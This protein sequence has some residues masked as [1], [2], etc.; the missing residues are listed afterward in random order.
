MSEEDKSIREI[1]EGI[2]ASDY[3]ISA[4]NGRLAV[5]LSGEKNKDGLE[6]LNGL[7]DVLIFKQ[8]IAQGWDCPRAAILVSYRNVRSEDFGIQTVGRI[9][10]MP[11]RKHYTH[12]DLNHGYVYTN[13]QTNQIKLVPSDSDYFDK[14]LAVRQ[15]DKSWEFAVMPTAQM[16]NDR[17]TSATLTSTFQ[18]I[19][20]NVMENKYGIKQLPDIDLFTPRADDD[21]DVKKIKQENTQKMIEKGWEFEID[22]HQ[23]KIPTDIKVDPY[24]VDAIQITS[25]NR[26]E[27]A[28]TNEEFR[29]FFDRFCYDSITRLIKEKSWRKMRETLINFAEYY[30]QSFEYDAR[31]IYLYPNNKAIILDDIRVALEKFDAWQH[32]WAGVMGFRSSLRSIRFQSPQN[33]DWSIILTHQDPRGSASPAPAPRVLTR[34]ILSTVQ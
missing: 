10:R 27:F 23:I 29:Q 24:Q 6:E 20:F 12:D 25:E 28:I 11:H 2:L 32:R 13:I 17:K 5:W 8:A 9:L 14:L 34:R 19:F 26:K 1:L 15:D 30:L 21:V 33:N 31:K 18:T 7:Q 4:N 3:Q 16:I 22:A